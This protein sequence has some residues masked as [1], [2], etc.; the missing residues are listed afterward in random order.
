MLLYLILL[1]L[2]IPRTSGCIEL[3]KLKFKIFDGVFGAS[4]EV[5]GA[6]ENGV[7]FE[8]RIKRIYD[9]CRD[10]DE[11]KAA[12]DKLQQDLA[13]EI[14]A[15][16]VNTR[17]QLFENFD[18][19]VLQR[20][21][22]DTEASLDKYEQMLLALTQTELSK[23]LQLVDGGF[24][25]NSLPEDAPKNIP[26]GEY[27]LPRRDGDCH[28]YRLKHPLA[29]W[30]IDTAKAKSLDQAHIVFDTSARETKVSV[31]EELKG[32]TG[33]LQV[34]QKSLLNPW[35]VLKITWLSGVNFKGDVIHSEVLE[36]L[37]SHQ[38]QSESQN[39]VS[40]NPIIDKEL[41]R[42]K[43][44]LLGDIGQRNLK[45]FEAEVE[46]LD[47]WADDLKVVLEQSIKRDRP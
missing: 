18:E 47:A 33:Q 32:Q 14:N 15:Q 20:L 30:A 42:A 40:L 39:L 31:V 38:V 11:I 27:E 2:P 16:M 6:I 7:D 37:L 19:D 43:Q 44:E 35:S 46:K 34:L 8:R 17:E 9:T 45:Y 25:I 3:L 29:Q 24:V 36:K 5:L 10:P 22:I 41:S 28:L 21:K 26:T 4:D 13:H 23:H 12:F 1:I